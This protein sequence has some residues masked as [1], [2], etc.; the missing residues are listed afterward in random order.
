MFAGCHCWYKGI[1]AEAEE[2]AEAAVVVEGCR[3]SCC[4]AFAVVALQ[5]GIAVVAIGEGRLG[6]LADCLAYQAV[7]EL[8]SQVA[9]AASA[10]V[11]GSWHIEDSSDPFAACIEDCN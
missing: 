11:E 10:N 3:R 7:V 5:V 4:A 2:I 8:A 1:A 6:W 9:F